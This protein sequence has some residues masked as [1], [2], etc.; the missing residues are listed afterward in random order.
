MAGSEIC[1]L[2]VDDED[3]LRRGLVTFLEDEGFEVLSVASGEEGIQAL[4]ERCVDVGIIDLRLPG[5]DGNEVIERA[6][7]LRPEMKVL[8]H[9]GSANYRLPQRLIALGVEP[10]QVFQ[11]PLEDM[12]VL[13][14][15]IRRLLGTTRGVGL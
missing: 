14:E 12:N 11:K 13:V 8:I 6:H 3:R 4:R 7:E 15:A 10:W 9:T 2:I 1:I 5:I